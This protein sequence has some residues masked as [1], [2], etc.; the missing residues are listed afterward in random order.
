[1]LQEQQGSVSQNTALTT[2]AMHNPH[3]RLAQYIYY[4]VTAE[5]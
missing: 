4:P 5:L 2:I 3:A 1:M